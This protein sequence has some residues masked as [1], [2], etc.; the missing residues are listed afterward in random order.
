MGSLIVSYKMYKKIGNSLN[1]YNTHA[2]TVT[3]TKAGSY[4]GD[5]QELI[6]K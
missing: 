6:M 2:H 3:H 1:V 5:H 4:E